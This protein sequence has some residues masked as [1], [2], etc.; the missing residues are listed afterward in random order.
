MRWKHAVLLV[1]ILKKANGS[2]LKGL[3][4]NLYSNCH[5]ISHKTASPT[6]SQKNLKTSQDKLSETLS[7]YGSK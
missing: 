3:K 6:T 7:A 2:S 1:L 4:Y 5:N